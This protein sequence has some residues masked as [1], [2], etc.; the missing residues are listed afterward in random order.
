MSATAVVLLGLTLVVAVGDWLALA[1]GDTALG[2][3]CKPL[4]LLFLALAAM[5]I[6]SPNADATAW[7]VMALGLSVAGELLLTFDREPTFVVAL[8]L[9]VA[10]HL[11]YVA[12][13]V[14]LGIDSSRI[15]VGFGVVAVAVV[16]VG[17]K[18]VG[19]VKEH[20]PALLPS[21]QA[22]IGV[23]SVVVVVAI[24]AGRP[25]GIVGA[26][27]FSAADALGGWNRYVQAH[28]MLPLAGAVAYH[29]GQI[30]LVLMLV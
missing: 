12:G 11:A 16:A 20:Q 18:I 3:L 28:P 29:L 8:T 15:L 19:G 17:P 2:Y 10:A 13:M 14:T 25:V 1:R 24:A 5:E 22:Y 23:I 7:I 6:A 9:F 4:V 21:I 30:G 27:L 26:G